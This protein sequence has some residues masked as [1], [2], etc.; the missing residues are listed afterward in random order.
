MRLSICI[1]TYNRA[2][3]IAATLDSL[4]GQLDSTCEVVVSDNASPDDTESIVR[5][6]S[7]SCG[8]LRYVRNATNI[9]FDRNYDNAVSHATGEYCW[10][11][12]DDDILKPGAVARV[13]NALQH[14]TSAVFVNV[15]HTDVTTSKV[16]LH[17]AVSRLTDRLYAPDDF[18]R[19]FADMA[20][21]Q[22]VSYIGGVVV[23]RD[24]WRARD[25]DR[26][27]GSLLIHVGV[28][29]QAPLPSG[30]WFISEPLVSVRMGN[31]RFFSSSD[32]EILFDKWPNL[33]ASLPISASSR[34]RAPGAEP[35]ECGNLFKLLALGWYS[36]K[37][38]ER[39]VLP[40]IPSTLKRV[41]PKII[42][43]I[44]FRLANRCLAFIHLL[45]SKDGIFRYYL[46]ITYEIARQQ[47]MSC[48]RH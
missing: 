31:T 4:I 13:L 38:Y 8:R 22:F 14:E 42:A 19:M 32:N 44:P 10:L 24:L 40:R 15:E 18:D 34:R 47:S 16:L 35:F 23:R 26:F 5:A 36:P 17:R 45:R 6:Y 12:S 30:A 33:L 41:V 28:I 20:E 27:F 2:N 9:G 37:D 48:K 25:R 7:R 21:N 11:M 29:Y 1:G 43:H 46:R 39:W 3:Y